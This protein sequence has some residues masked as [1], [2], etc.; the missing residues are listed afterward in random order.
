[1]LENPKKYLQ[2]FLWGLAGLALIFRPELITGAAGYICN[3]AAPIV[4]GIILAAVIDPAVSFFEKH[5]MR[6]V[7]KAAVRRGMAIGIVYIIIAAVI[8]G[9]VS[10]II[11]RLS[12]SVR[13]F[14]NSFDGY[15]SLLRERL[16]RLSIP[17]DLPDKIGAWLSS[18]LTDLFKK[19]FTATADFLRGAADFLFGAVLSVYILAGKEMLTDFIRE[20]ARTAMSEKNFKRAA[21]IISTVY[22]CLVNFISGQ[23]TEAVVLGTL[24]FAGMVIFGFEYPL[25]I[26]TI[27]GVTALVPV[28]GAFAGAVPSVMVLFLAKPS[29]ALWFIVF[30]IILQQIENNLIYPKVVGKSVG[31]P[32]MLILVAIILGAQT[33]G[34]VGIMLGI[35]LMSAGYILIKDSII[36]AG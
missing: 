16:D 24:C 22:E 6:L 14:V 12:D 11:P 35:P 21:R 13:L 2:P 5:L 29:S 18:G 28:V 7:K 23:L 19:T 36:S 8:T 26:S 17:V 27:I 30:I 1:M 20:A 25:L 3:A 34:A 9:A 32:S 15:Y 4:T 33:G 10:I 31:L